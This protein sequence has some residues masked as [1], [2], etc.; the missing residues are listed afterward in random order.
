[1]VRP[2][3]FRDF[4]PLLGILALGLPV[5]GPLRA[6][7]PRKSEVRGVVIRASDRKPIE[8]ARLSLEGTEFVVKSD[9]K[10]K[11]KFPKVAAGSYIL[12]AEVEGFPPA[13]STL[14][15]AKDDRLDVEF[16]VGPNDAVTLPE[17]SVTS[18]APSISPIPE[19]NRRATSG[20]G[21]FITREEIEKRQP[22]TLM[23]LM[24]AIPGV[25]VVCPQ[26]ERVCGL[27]MGRSNNRCGPA[28]FMDGLPTNSNV[29]WTT[30]PADVEAMEI[31]AG[32]SETPPELEGLRSG[33]GAVVIWTRVG[34]KPKD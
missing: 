10:G 29:L 14:L 20:R 19:F 18:D 26:T 24:R 25:H 27:Q 1:M 34:R 8:G 6:Q 30:P 33:C 3:A 2:S 4:L 17:L 7:E 31:Y 32:P 12:R 22:A 5:G 21:R 9:K 13:T 28:Y 16:Q 23:D 11:F 15:L